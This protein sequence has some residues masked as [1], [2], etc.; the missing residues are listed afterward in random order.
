MISP[1]HLVAV[2][3]DNERRHIM[4]HINY[5][6]NNAWLF[7]SSPQLKNKLLPCWDRLMELKE[8]V[9]EA[10]C[11]QFTLSTDLTVQQNN[12]IDSITTSPWGE[13]PRDE[14][15][16]DFPTVPAAYEWMNGWMD[17]SFIPATLFFLVTT[18]IRT[19]CILLMVYSAVK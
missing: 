15:V 14:L 5:P 4:L 18:E 3:D 13:T 2:L 16:F 19:N 7:L 10:G 12:S 1:V 17:G 6:Q 8:Y 11:D 9:Y